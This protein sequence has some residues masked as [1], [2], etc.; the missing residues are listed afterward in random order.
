MITV[1]LI[2]WFV[3]IQFD[4]LGYHASGVCIVGKLSRNAIVN[5]D[6]IVKNHL[7]REPGRPVT[8]RKR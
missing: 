3:R 2:M 5:N 4:S 8:C 7:Q 6:Q 1:L